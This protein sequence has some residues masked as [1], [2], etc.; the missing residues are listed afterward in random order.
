M[1]AIES[2]NFVTFFSNGI[3]FTP[4]YFPQ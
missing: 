1:A 2:D 3:K 4:S